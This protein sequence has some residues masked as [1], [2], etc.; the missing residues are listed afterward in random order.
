[1][2]DDQIS[3]SKRKMD[4][5]ENSR[6]EEFLDKKN[7]YNTEIN[8]ERSILED[9]C[10]INAAKTGENI[11]ENKVASISQI[12]EYNFDVN[13]ESEG[14]NKKSA[15]NNPEN[16]NNKMKNI[17]LEE[18]KVFCKQ[19]I[20]ENTKDFVPEVSKDSENSAFYKTIENCDL[21]D[22][23]DKNLIRG[24]SEHQ[25]EDFHEKKIEKNIDEQSKLIFLENNGKFE[26]I[27]DEY[28]NKR[29]K[30]A[31]IL[32]IDEMCMLNRKKPRIW[33]RQI[34]N[35]RLDTTKMPE[36]EKKV[37]S[38]FLNKINNNLDAE[39]DIF[40]D[41]NVDLQENSK[42]LNTPAKTA[43]YR[44]HNFEDFEESSDTKWI[45]RRQKMQEICKSKN[46]NEIQENKHL[47]MMAE[48]FL[49]PQIRCSLENKM[50]RIQN[51]AF[52]N[53]AKEYKFNCEKMMQLFPQIADLEENEETCKFK[54]LMYDFITR[55][56]KI[57]F[58]IREIREKM[59]KIAYLSEKDWNFVRK[60]VKICEKRLK[61]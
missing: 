24:I 14:E 49:A 13:I 30:S 31:K 17:N 8:A 11:T 15:D 42:V 9:E 25:S 22:S 19:K 58:M 60:C 10:A 53:M 56:Q 28:Q 43:N 16:S 46:K 45:S 59:S 44:K 20:D 12:C 38:A 18:E 26:D 23:L 51:F 32:D 21:K 52:L 3:P 36:I 35:Y 40:Y 33:H 6:E 39:S 1:M 2:K 55:N 48:Q 41:Y 37:I 50:L 57:L 47:K 5:A 27:C 7:C 4:E 61:K 54:A 34:E 29:F